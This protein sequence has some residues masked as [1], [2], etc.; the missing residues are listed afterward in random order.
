MATTSITVRVDKETK[1]AATK[2]AEDFGFDH[3][4]VTR[5]FFKRMVREQRMPLSLS[6]PEP[7]TESMRAT[8]ETDDIIANEDSH[9]NSSVE[10]SEDLD[11]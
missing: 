8:K 3:S 5:T 7:N 10:S 4:P 6:Y 11:I 2:I 9:F 1:K